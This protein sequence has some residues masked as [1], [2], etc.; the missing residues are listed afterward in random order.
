M[1][2]SFY[3]IEC[4]LISITLAAAG[5]GWNTGLL[6]AEIF[7]YSKTQRILQF[8]IEFLHIKIETRNNKNGKLLSKL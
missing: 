7:I 5:R 4:Q 3:K 1:T 8:H 2:I 6:K